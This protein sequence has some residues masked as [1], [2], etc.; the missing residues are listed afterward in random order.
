MEIISGV[1]VTPA[2]AIRIDKVNSLLTYIGRAAVA[3]QNGDPIWQI[4]RITKTTG[5]LT[6]IEYAD[7]DAEYDNI[8]DN[9]ASLS[10]S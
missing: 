9:H 4:M 10:Y 3:G 5:G 1:S 7:G 6:T 2:R 8:W